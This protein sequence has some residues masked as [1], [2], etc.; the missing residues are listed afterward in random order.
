MPFKKNPNLV[1]E[2]EFDVKPKL[3][4]IRPVLDI[5]K[6]IP[7]T[8]YYGSKRRLLPWIFENIKSLKFKTA[9]DG[10][11]GTGSVSLLFKAMGKD[12]TYHDGFSFNCHIAETVLGNELA[13]NPDAFNAF[14]SHV[15][16]YEGTIYTHFKKIF[17]TDEENR[18]LDGFVRK[19]NS[20]NLNQSQISLYQYTLFQACLKK[21]PFNLFHRAN[22]NLRLNEK[23][24]RSFGNKTTW[25]KPFQGLM[26]QSYGELVSTLFESTSNIKISRASSITC[27]SSGYDLVYLDPPYVRLSET[28]NSDDY[29]KRYHF[30]EGLSNYD[31]WPDSIDPQSNIRAIY[32]PKHFLE[33]SRKVSFK[34]KLFNLIEKHRS[35]TVVLSYVSGAYPDESEILAYFENK[36]PIV[37]VHS[38]DHSHALCKKRK[39]ELLFIGRQ[40]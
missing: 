21:R 32:Q 14:V 4:S 28:S 31:T 10:F 37:S 20:S 34:E 22:L 2:E 40:K 19:L 39:R 1:D 25:D 26:L 5:I 38:K 16:P 33:W 30:L 35:S 13:V 24:T 6:N 23:I 12:V 11:G 18:W 27:V 7:S 29:W 9:L 15:K 3:S 8:R 17:Y 36:F